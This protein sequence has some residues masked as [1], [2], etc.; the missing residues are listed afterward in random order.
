MK[1]F[2]FRLERVLRFRETQLRL[3][4]ARVSA[5]AGRVAGVRSALESRV[6]EVRES[7][8]EVVKGPTGAVLGT[9]AAYTGRAGRQILSLQEQGAQAQKA[10]TAELHL[11]KDASRKV[12]L[13]E[14]LQQK[15]R[16]R[17]Q[18]EFDREIAAFA[19]ESFTSRLHAA[20]VKSGGGTGA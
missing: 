8:A 20:R 11:L 15:G 7:A 6:A 5:A 19:D 10:L 17:W 18:G 14:K 2:A 12:R 3:G 16:N 4:E 1:A 13:L 9:Y